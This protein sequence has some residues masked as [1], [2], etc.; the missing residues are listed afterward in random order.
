MK[1]YYCKSACSLS[2]RIVLNEVDLKTKKTKNE[3]NYLKINP[4][5]AVPALRLDNGDVLTENQVIMQ[6][7]VDTTPK[8]SLLASVDDVK[9]YHTL[10]WVNYIAT[11]LHKTLGI[12]FHPSLSPEIKNFFMPM[13][14]LKL[15]YINEHLAKGPYLMGEHFTLPDAY[16]FVVIR[17]AYYFKMDLSAYKHLEHFMKVV[18]ERPAVITSL[19]QEKL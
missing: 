16:L 8:Q 10:E 17:W 6:Y 1:L 7:L 14:N 2:V 4:K 5:G 11:E 3:E 18:A 13:I 15:N 9:R 12:F 19:E